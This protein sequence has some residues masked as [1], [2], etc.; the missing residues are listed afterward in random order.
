MQKKPLKK[1]KTFRLLDLFMLLFLVGGILLLAYPFVSDALNDF[2][3]QQLITIYQK[4]ANLEN[5]KEVAQ[6]VAQQKKKN[7]ALVKAYC[8]GSCKRKS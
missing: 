5:E 1:H 4:K 6:Q 3:D 2:L 8:S 7:A